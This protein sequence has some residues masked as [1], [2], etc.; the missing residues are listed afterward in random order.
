M[1]HAIAIACLLALTACAH[2]TAHD[3]DGIPLPRPPRAGEGVL[4]EVRL[5]V[6]G[7]GQE[8]VVRTADGRLVG[9]VSPHG[10]H[11]GKGAGT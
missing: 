6:I 1:R 9:T 5:G 7:S 10:I 11:P 8:I 3:R 4:L 2:A